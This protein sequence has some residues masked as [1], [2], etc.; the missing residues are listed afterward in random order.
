VTFLQRLVAFDIWLM[1]KLGG[2]PGETL[3]SAAWNAHITLRAFGW[4]YLLID[5]GFYFWERDHCKR[6]HAHRSHIYQ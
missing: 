1:G 2:K 4:A 5:L 3:S 6:D